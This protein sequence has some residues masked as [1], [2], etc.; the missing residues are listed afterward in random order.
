MDVQ[1]PVLDGLTATKRIRQFE[2][3]HGL[4]RV[5]VIAHTSAAFCLPGRLLPISGV[6]AVLRKPC[7]ASELQECLLRWCPPKP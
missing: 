2:Y 1:M 6:D 7:D 4:P 3:E 5:P